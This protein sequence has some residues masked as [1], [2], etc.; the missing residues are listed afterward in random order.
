MISNELKV[1]GKQL[2]S[3]FECNH[4]LEI[5]YAKIQEK[6][7]PG[8]DGVSREVFERYL[9]TYTN[10]INRKVLNNTYQFTKYKQK[11]I[12]KGRNKSP[13]VISIPTIKDK[14]TLKIIHEILTDVFPQIKNVIAQDTIKKI[15][16]I[17]SENQYNSFIKIDIE[18]FYPSINHKILLKKVKSKISNRKINNL[19]LNALYN[20][21]GQDTCNKIG[22]PQ[23]LSISNLLADIYL[24]DLDF[25]FSSNVNYKYLRYV[26]DIIILCKEEDLFNIRERLTREFKNL[27]LKINK[28]KTISGKL[29]KG[30]TYLGYAY[31]NDLWTVRESSFQK[32]E[33]SIIR[34]FTEYKYSKFQKTDF[35]IW[36]LNLRITGCIYNKHGY[37]WLFFFSR[38]EDKKLLFHLDWFIKSML[39][40]FQ[41]NASQKESIKKFVRAFHEITK[42]ITN[43]GYIPN[44]DKE[45]SIE[46]KRIFLLNI[47]NIDTSQL[48]D[49]EVTN[50]YRYLI[51]QSINDL[52]VDLQEIY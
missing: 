44:Y 14:I 3:K 35:F 11:L 2:L 49:N 10:D 5:Y 17:V 52:E 43:S 12:S 13:R 18:N 26:D 27:K 51:S 28:D 15:K 16:K 34:I 45:T 21:T 32:L 46:Q 31:S 20:P 39:D 23:G 4:L 29:T 25:E 8:L 37:G 24:I 33:N 6:C 22:V 48:S 1:D 47:F 42:N 9:S 50:K 19:L 36:K 41:V 30:F 38:I 40:K 7:S